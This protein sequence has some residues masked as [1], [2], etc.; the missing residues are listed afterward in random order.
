M[1]SKMNKSLAL[2]SAKKIVKE[3]S[4]EIADKMSKITD[5]LD[6]I[7]DI[8]T[9]DTKKLYEKEK[10]ILVSLY[11]YYCK[12]QKIYSDLSFSQIL[13]PLDTNTIKN[14]DIKNFLNQLKSYHKQDYE[15]TISSLK[16]EDICYIK[17]SYDQ[18]EKDVDKLAN[19]LINI[20][21]DIIIQEISPIEQDVMLEKIKNLVNHSLIIDDY[22]VIEENYLK[23]LDEYNISK[24][25]FN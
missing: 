13:N 14:M 20:Q 5:H 3:K 21:S 10:N 22:K 9:I 17:I 15:V 4:L 8:D 11:D 16:K 23:F 1:F 24:E 18:L 12:F 7:K 25:T 6:M 19:T 2:N